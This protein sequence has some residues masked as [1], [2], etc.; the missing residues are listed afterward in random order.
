MFFV[1]VLRKRVCSQREIF[2]SNG[3]GFF[4]QKHVKLRE[5][6]FVSSSSV[7][8]KTRWPLTTST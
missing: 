3:I 6:A 5:R 1:E 2:V 4:Y 7:R 8:N